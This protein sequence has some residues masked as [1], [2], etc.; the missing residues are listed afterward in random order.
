MA[1]WDIQMLNKLF[2]PEWWQTKWIGSKGRFLS[3][4]S[5]LSADQS[6]NFDSLKMEK[7]AQIVIKEMNFDI[8]PYNT[9][10]N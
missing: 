2:A 1:D 5:L 9:S 4:I 7:L 8:S 6:N 3:F 10:M